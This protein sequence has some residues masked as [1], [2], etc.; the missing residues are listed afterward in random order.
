MTPI[1]WEEA[2]LR[3]LKVPKP[4]LKK[5]I[6]QE[7][8]LDKVYGRGAFEES[9]KNHNRLNDWS[10][11]VPHPGG[12]PMHGGIQRPMTLKPSAV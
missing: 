5:T 7:I 10:F 9:M 1:N 11:I 3:K 6:A 12:G 8:P 4:Y 2:M